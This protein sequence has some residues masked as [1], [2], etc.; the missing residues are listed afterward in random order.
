VMASSSEAM[1]VL[2]L[3]ELQSAEGPCLDAYRTGQPVLN[4]DLAEAGIRWP[5]FAAE[6]IAAGFRSVQAL[7]L[8][9]RSSVLGALNLFHLEPGEMPDDDVQAA[10]AMADIATIAIIQHRERLDAEIVNERLQHALNTRIVVEQAKG[11][12]AETKQLD[13]E[14]AFAVLRSYATNRNL[15]LGDVANDLI[16]GKL[17]PSLVAHRRATGS[18]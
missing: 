15:R 5:R 11:M 1:R 18:P 9:L 14:Q 13:M 10:Q 6:A 12:V 17:A 7:P 4:Q 16:D 3:F 8:R 2:E